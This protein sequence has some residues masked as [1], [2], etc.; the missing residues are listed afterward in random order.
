[1]PQTHHVDL[2]IIGSGS[3]NSIPDERFDDWRIALVDD[4]PHFGG[5]C[6]NVGCIP[7]KM[8][9]HP[10]DLART[11]EHAA[12]LG[13]DLTL[14][15]VHWAEIRDRIFGRIDPISAAGERYRAE[16]R[17]IQLFRQRARFVA[18]KTIQLT[19]GTQ[20]TADRY[21]LAAGSR[22]RIPDVPGLAETPY[23]TSDTVM[24]LAELPET[25]IIVGA[26]YVAA[27][28]AHVFSAYGTKVTLVG[29]GDRLLRHED[30]DISSRFTRSMGERVDLRLQQRLIGVRQESPDSAV[31]ASTA[32]SGR[33]QARV[34]VDIDGPDGP[35]TLTADVLLVATGRIPNGD[36][37]DLER[38][39]VA[40]GKNGYVVVDD[41]QRTTAEGIFALGDVSSY[42]QLKHVANQEARVVQ[43]N[44]LYPD[45]LVR[46]D[47]RFIPHAVFSSP[48]VASVG[49]TESEAK[50]RGLDYV[51]ALKPYAD[52]AYGWA[53]GE[54]GDHVVKLLA[55]PQTAQLIGAH[56]IGPEASS[57]IQPLIQAM[58][59][60]Q[61]AD[62]L[63]RGQYWIHPAMAEVIENALLALPFEHRGPAWAEPSGSQE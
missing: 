56:L 41:Y 47:H 18:D 21:V 20:I 58:S 6:L 38:T 39:G 59:F 35:A 28:F 44:L 33:S 48:Q 57:L 42:C 10:A 49:L 9:V 46:S 62:E 32:E 14:D 63:A 52:V 16:S 31:A 34:V 4:G 5:T 37:L 1:M 51:V 45:E 8:Y 36:R 50:E 7:T 53:M 23:E 15:Q 25:M 27:E 61:R 40:L 30:D 17:N 54:T 11:P 60:G 43:H 55:D 24:R 13:V 2:C 22:V 29:R 12:P 26:G 19:D 3:G